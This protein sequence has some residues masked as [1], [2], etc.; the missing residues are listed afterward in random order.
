MRF[1]N[2]EE[3]YEK[4]DNTGKNLAGEWKEEWLE[5]DRQKWA[6]KEGQDYISKD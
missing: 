1:V 4:V 2:Y 3:N 5:K 6:K